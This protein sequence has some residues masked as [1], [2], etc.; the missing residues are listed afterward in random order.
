MNRTIAR[1][2]Q[3][4]ILNNTY[5]VYTTDNGFHIS[6]HRLP[7]GKRCP[8][9]EDINVPMIMRGP[10]IP[11]GSSFDLVTS[12]TDLVPT[13]LQWTGASGVQ[14]PDG[15][16]IPLTGVPPTS[17]AQAWEH[18][19]VEHWGVAKDDTKVPD[20]GVIN[21]YKA[22]RIVS[23]S[24]SLFYSVWCDGSHEVYDMKVCRN[25]TTIFKQR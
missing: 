24:Y 9:E 4:N 10:G 17:T 11:K 2:E 13:I 15:V 19:Q 25:P 16:A 6:N 5:I 12:H 22:M 18:V 8:Y 1:L 7:P 3:H 14:D 23:S 21:T 20:N